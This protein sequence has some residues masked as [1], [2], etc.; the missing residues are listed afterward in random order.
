M[1]KPL[2]AQELWETFDGANAYGSLLAIP[3]QCLQAWSEA[4]QLTLPDD[5]QNAKRIAVCGMG[6]SGLGGRIVRSLY[7]EQLTA[8]LI[9][10]NTYTLPA[11]AQEDTLII[12]VSYSGSTEEIVALAREAAEKNLPLVIIAT[13][14]DLQEL[15]EKIQHDAYIFDDTK[16]NPANMPRMGVG[17][18][19][20]ALLRILNTLAYLQV[21]EADLQEALDLLRARVNELGRDVPTA[22]NP[23]KQLAERLVGHMPLLIASEHLLGNTY[24][25]R[26]QIHETAKLFC[27]AH[28][29]PELNHHLMEGLSH[30]AAVKEGMALLFT[31]EL[32]HP[33]IQERYGITRTVFEKQ[34]LSV[35]EVAL[36][37]A[38]KLQQSLELLQ[39]S[40]FLAY[41]LGMLHKEDPSKIPWV[42]FFKA[43]LS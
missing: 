35:E 7:A 6:G 17:L 22:Q 27:E 9:S 40:S 42:D 29:I 2:D 34:G 14:K 39:F 37:G 18:T 4:A 3:D 28:A 38:T 25:A 19:L 13:G 12:A 30:P 11:W 20:F 24:T 5:Y 1:N 21:D 41:Y 43:N 10:L 8:P 36:K 32:Y 15:S 23:A 33:R 16:T 26:N 31:S